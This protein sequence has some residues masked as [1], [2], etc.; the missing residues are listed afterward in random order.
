MLLLVN[1]R[2]YVQGALQRVPIL[3][4]PRFFCTLPNTMCSFVSYQIGL[5]FSRGFL[6]PLLI[7]WFWLKWHFGQ[8][9]I[10]VTYNQKAFQSLFF[11]FF[12]LQK[13]KKRPKCHFYSFYIFS[14]NIFSQNA[15]ALNV[16]GPKVQ[17][18]S[19]LYTFPNKRRPYA[20]LFLTIF[21]CLRS[22]SGA[23][24]Y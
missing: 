23:Y 14:L 19:L 11:M 6:K 9:T 2:A 15:F 1:I 21:P 16:P 4:S 5:N 20:Y 22:Y 24:A 10:K 18:S 3:D 13:Q 7:L 12:S 8:I 17:W